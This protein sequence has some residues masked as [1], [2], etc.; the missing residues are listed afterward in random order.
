ML[1]AVGVNGTLIYSS[2]SGNTWTTVSETSNTLYAATVSDFGIVAAGEN[3]TIITAEDNESWNVQTIGSGSLTIMDVD[4]AGD[5]CVLGTDS[6]YFYYSEDAGENWSTTISPPSSENYQGVHASDTGLFWISGANGLIKK[7]SSGHLTTFDSMTSGSTEALLDIHLL[8]DN[9]TGW[10]V[11]GN[12]TIVKTTD[13]GEN[14]TDVSEGSSNWYHVTSDP[15]DEDHLFVFGE[16]EIMESIDGGNKWS[17]VSLSLSMASGLFSGSVIDGSLIAAGVSTSGGVLITDDT[18][19]P[20][21]PTNLSTSPTS[22][23]TNLHP[24]LTWSDATDDKSGVEGYYIYVDGTL[25]D[26]VENG[27]GDDSSVLASLSE[28]THTLGVIAADYAEN[29]SSMATFTYTVD[30]TSPS[31]G[32]PSPTEVTVG[33]TATLSATVTDESS[34]TCDLWLNKVYEDSMSGSGTTFSKAITFSSAGE[35]TAWV[36]CTD[37]AGNSTTGSSA[38]ITVSEVA[39]SSTESTDPAEPT[40]SESPSSESGG[41]TSTESGSSS[42][43]A[44]S[45]TDSGSSSAAPSVDDPSTIVNDLSSLATSSLIKFACEDGALVNDPCTAVYYYGED[46]RRHAFPNSKVYFT[47]YDNFN[48]VIIVNKEVMSDLTLGSN[49]TYRPGVRMVK[50]LSW[51]TVYTVSAG[52][53]LRAVPSEEVATALYGSAWNTHIDDISDAFF[54]NYRFGDDLVSEN[55]FEP[56]EAENSTSTIDDDIAAKS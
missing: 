17:T 48:D 16:N 41:S 25:V 34:V 55:D 52:G 36:E 37:A 33:D 29:E 22:P 40:S 8:S 19:A 50:F 12:G 27:S 4:C 51:N 5:Y 45:S 20:S 53:E 14:W 39:E 31:V 56:T 49:V 21:A 28:G 47:W 24:T 32:I 23:S 2:D 30:T 26:A 6:G 54:S 1:V 38:T 11:G 7:N 44:E 43:S 15:S 13:G 42:S 9:L 10:A 46:G 3:G 18:I 35:Q